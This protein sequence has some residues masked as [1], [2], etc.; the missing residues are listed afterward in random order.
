MRPGLPVGQIIVGKDCFR[1]QRS[2][3]KPTTI[4]RVTSAKAFDTQ[5]GSINKTIATGN[6]N[7]DAPRIAAI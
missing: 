1:S 4:V 6:V 3:P 7:G 5:A 2:R